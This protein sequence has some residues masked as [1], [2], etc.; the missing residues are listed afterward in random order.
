VDFFPF[1]KES[2]EE[3]MQDQGKVVREVEYST[4]CRLLQDV[5]NNPDIKD[6]IKAVWKVDQ[7]L[8][9]YEQ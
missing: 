6:S 9:Y 5:W 3:L 1:E 2:S 4:F 7:T 8:L